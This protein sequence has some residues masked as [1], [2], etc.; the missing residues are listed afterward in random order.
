MS[1]I[2]PFSDAERTAVFTSKRVIDGSDWIHY[3]THDADDGAWQFHPYSGPTP[4]QEA[5]V[6]SLR[7]ILDL[8]DSVRSLSDLPRGWHAWRESTSSTWTRAPRKQ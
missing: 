3:V 4:E 8:D 6:V 5:A 2:W 7:S 1:S